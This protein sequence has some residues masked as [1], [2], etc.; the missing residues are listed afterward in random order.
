[1]KT[2]FLMIVPTVLCFWIGHSFADDGKKDSQK[3]ENNVSKLTS[4]QK[5]IGESAFLDVYRVLQHPRCL[6][7]HPDGEA[8]LQGDLSIPHAMNI[9]RGS[10]EAGLECATC[11]QNK[12]SEVL[13][14]D[15]G[16]PGAPNWHLPEQNM[17]LVFQ[18][19]SPQQLCEQLKDPQ[20]N[21]NKTLQQVYDHIAYDPLVLW[22]WEPGGTRTTP[23]LTHADFTKQ[24]KM[25]MDANAPCPSKIT[26]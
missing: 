25:W 10:E 24:F 6:N 26:D 20:Q 8:P 5:A 12:N 3:N 21:G 13:G 2:I 22:G 1:M 14:I 16:P 23:P 7:C 17:P 4:E 15:G 11:H 19:R 18:N 9:T